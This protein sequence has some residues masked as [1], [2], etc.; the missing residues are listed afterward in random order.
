MTVVR[1]RLPRAPGR[2]GYRR[3][4][5]L[6]VTNR[7]NVKRTTSGRTVRLPDVPGVKHEQRYWDRDLVVAGVDEVGRGAWAGPVTYAAVVLPSDRR[8]YKL[9]D[10]KQ[11]DPE[12]R[13]QLHDRLRR[14]A[15]A[16]GVG[17]ASNREIDRLGMSAAI[18]L[19]AGRAVDALPLLPDVL[20]LDGNWDFLSH[21]GVPTERIVYGDAYSASIAAASVIAKVTR[22]RML[23]AWHEDH[24]DY[25]FASNKGY[26]APAHLEALDDV[27]ACELHRH[28]W[29]PIAALRQTR[30]AV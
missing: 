17:H 16:I 22:D 23:V 28:S 14:F 26:P 6:P 19:A 1:G 27:G 30:L 4:M 25:D 29:E 21:Y 15:L 3:P 24:P 5:G 8:I 20:L 13:E 18:R 2:A 12:R 7:K 11:L 9:R 10:S